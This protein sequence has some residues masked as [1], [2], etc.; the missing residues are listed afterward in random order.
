MFS[1]SVLPVPEQL[2][3]LKRSPS[4]VVVV[5]TIIVSWSQLTGGIGL[6]MVMVHAGFSSIW[7]VTAQ[8]R[9]NDSVVLMIFVWLV[10]V[11]G[12][13]GRL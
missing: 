13:I 4:V 2:T 1:D 12:M 5:S 10:A 6:E 9:E 11:L 8:V 3:L 7:L